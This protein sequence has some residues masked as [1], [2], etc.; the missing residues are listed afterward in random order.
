MARKTGKRS[1]TVKI[2]ENFD[3]KRSL[4]LTVFAPFAKLREV[5]LATQRTLRRLPG[6]TGTT[7]IN[8]RRH[9]RR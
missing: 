7:D 6:T 4:S 3:E 1:F 2:T 9:K 5:G 8:D